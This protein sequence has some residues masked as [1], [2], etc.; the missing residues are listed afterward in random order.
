MIFPADAEMDLAA[1]LE[2][3]PSLSR[4]SALLREHAFLPSSFRSKSDPATAAVTGDIHV[5]N[6]VDG[7]GAVGGDGEEDGR[8][9]WRDNDDNDKRN[10]IRLGGQQT[11]FTTIFAPTNDALELLE[12]QRPWLFHNAKEAASAAAAAAAAVDGSSSG[13]GSSGVEGFGEE[14]GGWGMGRGDGGDREW[15]PIR[16]LL[17]YHLVPDAAL[18]SRYRTRYVVYVG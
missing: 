17:A 12:E 4:F 10:S 6:T 13:S 1:M 16:E 5:D 18:F 15:S 7:F 14:G 3:I 11:T 8:R 9:R 2:D